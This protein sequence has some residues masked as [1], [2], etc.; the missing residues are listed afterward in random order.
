MRRGR[1][2]SRHDPADLGDVPLGDASARPSSSSSI[3][4]AG[5]PIEHELAVAL[6]R[7]SR[8]RRRSAGAATCWRSIGP[9]ASASSLDAALALRQVLQQ[10]QPLR[11]AQRLRHVGEL[12]V[13]RLLRLR[14]T[15]S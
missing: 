3:G 13:D 8:A 5:E 4:V 11:M 14:L 6:G 9:R 15:S 7:R 1:R 2:N 12:L 10:L